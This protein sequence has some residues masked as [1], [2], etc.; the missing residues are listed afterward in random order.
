MKWRCSCMCASCECACTLNALGLTPELRCRLMRQSPPSASLQGASTTGPAAQMLDKPLPGRRGEESRPHS[1]TLN[2]S[3]DLSFLP[4][5]QHP[6]L[7]LL[8]PFLGGPPPPTPLHWSFFK[9]FSAS[10]QRGHEAQPDPQN[11]EGLS[12][13]RQTNRSQP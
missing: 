8:E 12:K 9:H 10:S 2:D 4:A 11:Q 13:D 3:R 6:L 1:S 5:K 7:R